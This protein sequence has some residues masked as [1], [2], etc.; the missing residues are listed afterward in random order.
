MEVPIMKY[1]QWQKRELKNSDVNGKIKPDGPTSASIKNWF[2]SFF[3]C[4]KKNY[5][6]WGIFRKK[7]KILKSIF[8][9][10]N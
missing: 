2:L 6:H 4:S 9:F 1:L 8:F 7:K 3:A 5:G 10:N